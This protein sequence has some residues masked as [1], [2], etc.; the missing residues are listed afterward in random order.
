MNCCFRRLCSAPNKRTTRALSPLHSSSSIFVE[1]ICAARHSL[2]VFAFCSPS[3]LLILK[4]LCKMALVSSPRTCTESSERTYAASGEEQT[5]E[6][7]STQI[8]QRQELNDT[9]H[10][11]DPSDRRR[12]LELVRS[13]SRSIIQSASNAGSNINPFLDSHPKLDP[14]SPEFDSM[15]WAKAFLHHSKTDPDRYP[16][17][18]VGLSFRNLSVHGFGNDTDFQKNVLNVLLQGPMMAKQ[19]ISQRRQRID[20]LKDFD[21]LIRS[22]EIL[23]VLGRPGR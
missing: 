17:P 14:S 15:E 23:L 6:R 2:T 12:M 3:A 8:D 16:R 5:S 21:G 13:H 22:G 19:W 1:P 4:F 18:Q 20:I 9:N 11:A 7:P 10:T